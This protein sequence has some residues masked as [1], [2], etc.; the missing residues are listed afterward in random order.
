MEDGRS[1]CGRNTSIKNKINLTDTVI[2]I[3]NNEYNTRLLTN[4]VSTI[5]ILKEIG[6][7]E[8]EY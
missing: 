7:H 6:T 5:R 2:G 4:T 8:Y 3:S 1:G